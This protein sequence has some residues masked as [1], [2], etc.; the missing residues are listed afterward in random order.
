MQPHGTDRLRQSGTKVILHSRIPKDGWN[1]RVPKT[2]TSVEHPG[3]AVLIEE[4]WYEVV[5]ARA[6][7]SG[8]FEYVL[9]P[10]RDENAIRLSTRYDAEAEGKRV[11]AHQTEARRAKKRVITNFLGI[12]VGHLPGPVQ[13]H[14]GNE[15][16]IIAS[17]LT[18]LSTLIGWA[19]FAT[20]VLLTVSARMEGTPRV[21][22]WLWLLAMY[23]FLDS[24]VRSFVYFSQ[25]RPMGSLLGTILYTIYYYVAPNRSKLVPLD[26][27]RGHK[28]FTLPPPDDVALRDKV[29]MS[30][31]LLTLLTADEQRRLMHRYE[32]WY[33]KDATM[34]AV[35]ILVFASAGAVV[36]AHRMVREGSFLAFV[37]MVVAGFVAVEQVAR[38]LAFRRGPAGSVLGYLAR[39]FVRGL[40]ERG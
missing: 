34:V 16:G 29:E 14:F 30:S 40:L 26:G 17:R 31:A 33:R 2:S 4:Q 38:L 25:S 7:P 36:S 1:P 39:P 11:E 20:C 12:F 37:S 23:L 8:T 15:Y 6:L 21:P 32:W 13:E 3:V 18:I 24:L 10:W 27:G 28:L 5:M 19:V 22:V 9:E 35:G